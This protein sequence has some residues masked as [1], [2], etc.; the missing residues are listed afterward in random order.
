LRTV[1]AT[2]VL[3][4]KRVHMAQLSEDFFATLSPLKTMRA[5]AAKNK[6]IS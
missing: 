4:D 6:K 3:H 2:P 1:L 5:I